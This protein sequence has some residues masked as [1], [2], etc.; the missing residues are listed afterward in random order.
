MADVQLV[1]AICSMSGDYVTDYVP[2]GHDSSAIVALLKCLFGKN[3]SS[4]STPRVAPYSVV[5]FS[6]FL[7]GS[8]TSELSIVYG[9]VWS[10]PT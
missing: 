9:T 3:N 5:E 4:H 8:H 6:N 2:S 1:S 7:V 10:T